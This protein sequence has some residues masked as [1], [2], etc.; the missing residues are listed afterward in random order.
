VKTCSRRPDSNPLPPGATRLVTPLVCG[1]SLSKTSLPPSARPVNHIS[2]SLG[3]STHFLAHR[4]IAI[5]Q[6]EYQFHM[7]IVLMSQNS[8]Y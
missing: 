8:S 6:P 2:T 5:I 4:S 7:I 1:S 3:T